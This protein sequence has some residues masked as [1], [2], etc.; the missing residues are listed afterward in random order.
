MS[1]KLN[2]DILAIREAITKKA[3]LGDQKVDL[4]HLYIVA[5]GFRLKRDVEFARDGDRVLA[6]DLFYPADPAKPVAVIGEITCDNANRMG[7]GSMV[8]C[9]DSLIEGAQCAGFAAAMIDHPVRP[10]YKGIDDPMPE[11][12]DRAEAA[13]AKLREQGFGKVGVIGFSRGAPFAAMLAADR[14]ADAALVHGN[15]FDYLALE[16]DDPML[17]RFTK[18][19][20][21]PK[22]NADRW[23]SHGT[24]PLL[25]KQS[26][27]MFLNTSDAESKEY[28]HGL[29]QLDQSLTKL[30]VE[31]A[32]QVDNDGRGHRMTQDPKTLDAIYSFFHKHLD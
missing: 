16:S 23:A 14:T 2:A 21:D 19:W 5:E 27:P 32:Y 4:N 12:R 15:R 8:F 18:A 17:A 26:S 7:A 11:S 9:R 3:L 29:E 30:G 20:G 1:P 28:R 25:T 24:I 13:V 10:P 6:M 31:H 22:T